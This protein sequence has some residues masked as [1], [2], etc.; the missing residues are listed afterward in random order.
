MTL[1]DKISVN[2]GANDNGHW[3]EFHEPECEENR[4]AGGYRPRWCSPKLTRA[5]AQ[6][7]ILVL[8]QELTHIPLSAPICDRDE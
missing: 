3:I 5:E 4:C 1:F 7:L 8:L 6:E 2:F